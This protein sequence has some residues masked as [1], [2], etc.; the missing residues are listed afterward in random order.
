[1]Q[2]AEAAAVLNSSLELHFTENPL[3]LSRKQSDSASSLRAPGGSPTCP[4]KHI[5]IREEPEQTAG[6]LEGRVWRRGSNR[7]E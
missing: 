5:S 3:I 6:M 4:L 2:A 1:M 7:G